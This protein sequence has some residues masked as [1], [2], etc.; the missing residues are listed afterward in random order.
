M[1]ELEIVLYKKGRDTANLSLDEKLVAGR[2]KELFED[3][4]Q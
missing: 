3:H 1:R 4:V 2:L